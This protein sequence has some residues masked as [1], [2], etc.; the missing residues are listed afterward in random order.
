MCKGLL[1]LTILTGVAALGIFPANAYAAEEVTLSTY[2]PAPYGDYDELNASELNVIGLA[3]FNSE[4]GGLHVINDTHTTNPDGHVQIGYDVNIDAGF[5]RAYQTGVNYRP[6]VINAEGSPL[7][8]VGIGT[9]TPGATLDIDAVNSPVTAGGWREAIRF[10]DTAPGGTPH[11]AITFPAGGLLFGMHGNRNF[12]FGDIAGG[13]W[14]KYVMMIEGDTGNV[15]IGGNSG[16]GVGT[17]PHEFNI[18][19][20]SPIIALYDMNATTEIEMNTYIGFYNSAA[21]EMAWVGYGSSAEDTFRIRSG[22][23][24][25]ALDPDGNVGINNTNPAFGLDIS[26]ATGW[27]GSSDN[28][29]VTGGWRLGMWPKYGTGTTW[30]YLS[31]GDSSAYQDLAVG[32]LYAG[33]SYYGSTTDL[34]EM[35]NVA[36]EDKLEPGDLV[37][38]GP[39][40]KLVKTKGP[41]DKKLTGV[42]SSFDTAGLVIGGYGTPVEDKARPDREPIALVGQVPTKVNVENGA[43]SIG[44]PLTSSSIP[45]V[46]MK[47]TKR[48][49]I[50]GYAMEEFA[51]PKTGKIWVFVNLCYY[52]GDE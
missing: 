11:S 38:F 34:A 13:V 41:Y 7:S 49:K 43:I 37:S 47:A 27:I 36:E 18:Y 52:I 1:V 26:G 24:T 35:M 20:P 51:G 23:T 29:Q 25:I 15:S 14:G 8:Y 44:D 5:I 22:S 40:K 9:T 39:D 33:G 45:G 10:S 50:I 6:L 3:T 21:S 2:Y 42:V 19:G 16:A 4:A 12:Y 30:C 48:C 17:A 28:S 32:S 31:R 46:A